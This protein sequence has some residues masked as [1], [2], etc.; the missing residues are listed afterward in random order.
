MDAGKDA[1]AIEYTND[2][3]IAQKAAELAAAKGYVVY[4]ADSLALE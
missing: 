3:E 1:Y 2:P 4:I